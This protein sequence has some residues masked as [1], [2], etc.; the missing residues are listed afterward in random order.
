MNWFLADAFNSTKI[1]K[2][3]AFLISL[4]GRVL[5]TIV[6]INLSASTIK[7]NYTYGELKKNI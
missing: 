2:Y 1:T 4:S 7:I 6:S 5:S 3:H